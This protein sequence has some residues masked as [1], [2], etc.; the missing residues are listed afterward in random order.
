[1]FSVWD[2]LSPDVWKHVKLQ[3]LLE[4]TFRDSAVAVKE[5]YRVSH[6]TKDAI[7]ANTRNFHGR[8]QTALAAAM[9]SAYLLIG[10]IGFGVW[11]NWW[12]AVA[13][14]MAAVCIPTTT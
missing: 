9:A 1:M 3:A 6:F 4:R 10:N 7:V 14:M 13:W 2:L 8:A 5:S 12:L 11:Q